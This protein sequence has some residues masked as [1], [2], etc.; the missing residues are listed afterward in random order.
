M[1][2]KYQQCFNLHVYNTHT[3]PGF[4]D[5]RTS[6]LVTLCFIMLYTEDFVLHY[7]VGFLQIRFHTYMH[8]VK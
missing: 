2:I 5:G 3:A 1:E 6:I 4:L 8:N 7:Y